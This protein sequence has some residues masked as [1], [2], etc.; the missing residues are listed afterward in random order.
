MTSCKMTSCK[1]TSCKVASCKVASCSGIAHQVSHHHAAL[2]KLALQSHNEEDFQQELVNTFDK[3]RGNLC[4]EYLR[5]EHYNSYSRLW[6][7]QNWSVKLTLSVGLLII[8]FEGLV[9][10]S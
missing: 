10:Y 1:M 7:Q 2:H 6:K 8:N 9:I 4:E 5:G 3:I